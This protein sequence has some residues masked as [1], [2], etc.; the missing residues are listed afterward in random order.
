VSLYTTRWKLH[1]VS[2][3]SVALY[4]NKENNE[5]SFYTTRANKVKT[6]LNIVTKKKNLKE[7]KLKYHKKMRIR[8]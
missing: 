8:N 4:L 5:A 6:A 1:F 2:C 3:R 7:K